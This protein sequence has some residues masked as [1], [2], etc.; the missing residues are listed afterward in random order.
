MAAVMP[1]VRM[2]VMRVVPIPVSGMEEPVVAM[3]PVT[4]MMTT[5]DIAETDAQAD[6][7]AAVV[8]ADVGQAR[9]REGEGSG[10]AEKGKGCGGGFHARWD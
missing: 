3:V 2:P 10:E 9:R 1:V 8:V 4:V 6:A 7:G 5:V